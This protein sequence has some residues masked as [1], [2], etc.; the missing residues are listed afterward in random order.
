MAHFIAIVDCNSFYA[1]CEKVFRPDLEGKPVLVLSNND[2]VVIAASSEAKELGLNGKPF[3]KIQDQ[4]RKYDAKVFSSNY[5][6]YGDISQRIM[7]TLEQFCPK[8]EVYSI[9]EA[10]LHFNN[11]NPNTITEHN[12]KIREIIKKWIG[13]P[14]TIGIAKTKTLAK[15]ANRF[16]K[17]NKLESG[18]LNLCDYDD[19]TD[20]L[21]N[22]KIADVWGVG[23]QYRKL[24]EKYGI[25][26]AY[27]F[28]NADRKWVRKRMTVVGERTWL[29]LNGVPCVEIEDEPPAK[30][31]IIS[32]RSFGKMTDSKEEV[33]EAVAFFT[34]RAAEK[35]RKQK[36]A[37]KVMSV[38][39]RTN[40]FKTELAQYHNGVQ[41][42]L[43]VPTSITGELVEF[44]LKGFEQIWRDTYL[45]QKVG[46][47]LTELVPDS[48]AQ[49]GL[50]DDKNR[51]NANIATSTMD[52][53]NEKLG[54]NKVFVA[55]TGNKRD[56]S[57]KR[58]FLSPRYTTYW[59]ELPIVKASMKEYS[60]NIK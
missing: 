36:S 54:S 60:K 3:F 49:F 52:K 44:A 2:G 45:Y 8:V 17:K 18:V 4:I 35:M 32:S 10:F 20:F 13:M 55:S 53:I 59:N 15:I 23:S 11:F 37:A 22:T 21:A 26:T 42:N 41:I 6:L 12:T 16:A 48:N 1:S 30:K 24:L 57:M 50:F 34:S 43:P 51:M 27:D 39:L 5:T 29:E 47:M 58:E 28:A 56:W 25:E 46:V 9:D 19:L 7:D 40:K 31:A 14:V 38:F 33:S